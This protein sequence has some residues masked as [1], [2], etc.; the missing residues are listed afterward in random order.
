MQ[1]CNDDDDD[2][3]DN[4][5][6]NGNFNIVALLHDSIGLTLYQNVH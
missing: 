4:D 1:V 3:D 5:E 2:D 6:H